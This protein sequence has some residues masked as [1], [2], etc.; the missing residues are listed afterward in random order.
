MHPV[1]QVCI[2]LVEE[3][4]LTDCR[5][6][7]LFQMV[8]ASR[9]IP[10]RPTPSFVSVATQTVV[11]TYADASVEAV[12]VRCMPRGEFC[13]LMREMVQENA[14]TRIYALLREM[15][16][17]V[18]AAAAGTELL[19]NMELVQVQRVQAA[20]VPIAV[21]GDLT[22]ESDKGGHLIDLSKDEVE[23]GNDGEETSL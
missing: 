14:L 15:Q 6:L 23:E 16:S 18:E 4:K 13:Q 5:I 10:S 21:E 17:S 2:H 8:I 22:P 1:G 7:V 9:S 20:F 11:R 3:S 19:L 12:N